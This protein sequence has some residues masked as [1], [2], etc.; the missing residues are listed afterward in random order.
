MKLHAG[1]APN[2]LRVTIFLGEKGLEIPIAPTHVM[3]GDTKTDAFLALNPLGEIPVLELDDG[4]VLTESMAICRYLEALHPK[5]SLFGEDAKSQAVTEMWNRRM[6]LKVFNAIGDFARHEFPF[7]ADRGQVP[8]FTEL[9][10]SDF[11]N[12]LNWLDQELA[13][14]RPFIAGDR[15]S[16]ADI[17]GMAMLVL[18]LFAEYD[19]EDGHTH[20]S[21]WV[22]SMKA[23]PSFPEMPSPSPE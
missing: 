8:A 1:F 23:R 3:D 22:R 6:E 20:L 12:V 14:G 18:A 19:V 11:A 21:R 7:F 15:F 13:D 9:R 10:R 4:T 2:A 16:V 5:P 17:T